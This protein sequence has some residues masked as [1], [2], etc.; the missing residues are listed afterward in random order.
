MEE[1]DINNYASP[2]TI[3]GTK[4]LFINKTIPENIILIGRS[5]ILLI[6]FIQEN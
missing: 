1:V 6:D 2:I 4:H 3:N 5:I